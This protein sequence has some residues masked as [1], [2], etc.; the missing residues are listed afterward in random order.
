MLTNWDKVNARTAGTKYHTQQC[1]SANTVVWKKGRGFTCLS[2]IICV[3]SILKVAI[4]IFTTKQNKDCSV[5]KCG[6]HELLHLIILLDYLI[7]VNFH[8]YKF[9][10]VNWLLYTWTNISM[11]CMQ[12]ASQNLL[13][14]VFCM[15]VQDFDTEIM[16]SESKR[17]NFFFDLIYFLHLI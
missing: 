15:F 5:L 4:F 17:E 3:V 16:K 10:V 12:N 8:T 6:L 7:F 14:H 1:T 11:L 9:Q 2:H 13:F